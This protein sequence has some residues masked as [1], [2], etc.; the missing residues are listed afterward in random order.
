M[1]GEGKS[2]VLGA[3]GRC[4]LP[5]TMQRIVSD[6]QSLG[7]RYG[8]SE[9]SAEGAKSR[10]RS[11]LGREPSFGTT[12][13]P[14]LRRFAASLGMTPVFLA[15]VASAA[16]SVWA[17]TSVPLDSA[18]LRRV[19]AAESIPVESVGEIRQ[20]ARHVFIDTHTNPSAGR[21]IV[22]TR[23]VKRVITLDG[24]VLRVLPGDV[25][26]YHRSSVH[27]APTHWVELS[28]W[29]PATGRDHPLYPS[30]PP[31]SLRRAYVDTVRS[32]YRRVGEPWFHA[33]NHHMDPERFDSRLGDT[34]VV[35]SSGRSV[36]FMVTFGGGERT[37]AATPPLE[38]AVV[39]RDVATRRSRCT[40]W[41]A[42]ELA[43]AHP[44]WTP[45][46]I[47]NDLVGRR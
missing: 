36:A 27:F 40:E 17:Q 3:L 24:W 19:L 7:S 15:A 1:A 34:I 11:L 37:P 5:L 28:T 4:V 14:R 47:L 45:I 6:R 41:A 38:V 22:L 25:V 21:I 10:N 23:D 39:C 43:R 8:H 20:T 2:D 18:K 35:S 46:Q 33:N 16:S 30:E 9:R 13:I 44:G 26:L 12:A 31:D 32:I 29:D 42:S